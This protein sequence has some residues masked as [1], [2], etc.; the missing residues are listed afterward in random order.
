MSD[1][2]NIKALEN[3][4]V[5][6]TLTLPA[7]RIEEDYQKSL[8]KY[9]KNAQ[10]PGFRKGHVPASVLEKKFGESLRTET[11]FDTMEAFL[12]EELEK[13]DDAQ[14]PLPYCT[15]V[16]QDEEKLLPFKKDTDVTFSVKYDVKPQFEL[17]QYTGMKLTIPNVKVT[18]ADVAKELDKLREQNAMVVDKKDGVAEDGNIVNIDYV[19]LDKDGKEVKASERKDFT[20]TLGSGYN[21]YEIDKEVAGMKVGE[22]KTIEKNYPKEF[23]TADLAGKTVTLKVT[24]KS[25]KVKDVPALDD[26]FAQ[27][28]KEEYKTV[29]DLTK[30][31]REKLEKQLADK[32]SDDKFDK[33]ADEL[34]KNVKI[35]L[36]QSMVD[37]EL[38]RDWS[39]YIRQT[40]LSEDQVLK[41]LSF[42]QKDKA[43][44]QNEW[45]A[46]AEKTLRVQLVMDKIKEKEK[47]T[48]SPEELEKAEKEQLKD[49]TDENQKKYYRTLL[50][51]DLN[52]NKVSDF[53]E[54]NNT[55]TPDKEMSFDAYVNGQ[56]ATEAAK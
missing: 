17:P 30:A 56:A 55:F 9:V 24:L 10:I 21:Y 49:V 37:L 50:E 34:A 38:D 48:V 8:A 5:E 1:A 52:F 46:D 11:T 4:S 12:K 14:K 45:K 32:L 13:L 18:D 15:P 41:F 2:K 51:E 36:P 23:K 42:Q 6:L 53:L 29:A 20:F 33:I 25:V 40:G 31:T 26:E 47:F 19:E 43:A 54:A 27:D 7:A 39:N 44:L 16:L 35:D 28:I 22:T 3:S